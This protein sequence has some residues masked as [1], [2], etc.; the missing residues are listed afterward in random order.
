ML[1]SDLIQLNEDPNK[2]TVSVPIL[3]D[4]TLMRIYLEDDDL[5]LDH[6]FGNE[7]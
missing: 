2:N 6:T 1:Y 5:L 7:K 3:N 4:G